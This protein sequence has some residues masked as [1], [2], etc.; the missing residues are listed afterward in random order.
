MRINVEFILKLLHVLYQ[1]QCRIYT[2]NIAYSIWIRRETDV[3]SMECGINKVGVVKLAWCT[4][5]GCG[6]DKVE[7][8]RRVS[9]PL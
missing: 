8:Y 5:S 9:Q 6:M 4:L 1:L 7:C 2:K 3:T